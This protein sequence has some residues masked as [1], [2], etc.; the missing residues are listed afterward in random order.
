MR[1]LG[2]L[3]RRLLRRST[4]RS[5]RTGGALLFLGRAADNAKVWLALAGALAAS[6]GRF[7]RR[8]ALRGLFAV[9]IASALTNGPVKLA[10]RRRRPVAGRL[11]SGLAGFAQS[12]T[13]SFPSGHSASAFAFAVGAGQEVPRLAPPLAGLAGLVAYSRVHARAHYPSDVAVGALVGTAA[14]LVTRRLWPVA[15]HEPAD[16]RTALNRAEVEPS[17]KGGGLVVVVNPSAGSSGRAAEE[18]RA[19][20][21][22]AEVVELD[23]GG[24]LERALAG[25]AD[26]GCAIG[27]AG[28]D[29]SVNTAAALAAKTGKPLFVVPGGTLNHFAYALGLESIADAARAVREGR[30]VAVDRGVVDGH[31]FVNT[32]SIGSYVDLVDARERLE[33]TIGKWP[34]VVLAL[35]RVLRR[36]GPI[37]MEIDGR[38]RKVWMMFIG[39]CAYDPPGFA[40]SWRSRLDDGQLDVRIVDGTQPWSRVRLLLSVMTGRLARCGAYEQRYVPSLHVKS[41]A[42]HLRLARDGETFDG[43]EEFTITKAD[44]PLLVYAPES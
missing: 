8:A 17:P 7:R 4:R 41:L 6:G 34:A 35:F 20:L 18:L 40:P 32:A 38:R 43:P 9:A 22:E 10:F 29:G 13:S 21:P 3:D 1:R 5:L 26:R 24:E 2:H 42:G 14:G 31:S 23:D 11:T 16:V 15:P 30:A 25:A 27:V 36:A 12:G 44:E 37:E 33:D 19:E 28:G 39:N